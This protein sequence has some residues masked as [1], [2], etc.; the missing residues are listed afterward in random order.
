MVD[1]WRS[2]QHPGRP[3]DY[4]KGQ[5]DGFVLYKLYSG[6][7]PYDV[8]LVWQTSHTCIPK[9]RKLNFIIYRLKPEKMRRIASCH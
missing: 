8:C 5:I 1:N 3:P 2:A 7:R 6:C 9:A 4:I